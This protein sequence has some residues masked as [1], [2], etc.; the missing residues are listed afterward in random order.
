[1]K[2][3]RYYSSFQEDFDQSA[4]QNYCIPED[5]R[6]VRTDLLSKVLSGIVYLLAIVIGEIYCRCFLHMKIKGRKRLKTIKGNFFLYGNHTQPIGDVFIPALSLFPR[7]IYTLVSPANYGIPVIGKMLPYLGALPVVPSLRGMKALNHAMDIRLAQKHPVVIYPEAHVW[8][9]YP[10]IR[11]F[12]DTAFKYPVKRKIP[13]F[14]MTVTY[15]KAKCFKRP[16]MEVYIDGPYFPVGNTP[17]EQATDLHDKIYAVM[18]ERS[19]NSDTAYIEYYPKNTL[20]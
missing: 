17:K 10:H 13:S 12:P 7:R 5:Y 19:K 3:V 2:Q 1:M 11:P 9:Y 16:I 8:K 14:A 20:P 6:W 4:E 18:T 15:R